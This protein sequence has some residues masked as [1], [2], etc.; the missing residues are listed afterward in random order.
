MHRKKSKNGS[1]TS[2]DSLSLCAL[3]LILGL[4]CFFSIV[5]KEGTI[6]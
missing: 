1:I 6:I 3:E 2:L 4:V 5:L